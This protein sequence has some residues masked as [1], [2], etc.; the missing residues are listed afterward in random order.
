MHS[1]NDDTNGIPPGN[2]GHYLLQAGGLPH[3]AGGMNQAFGLRARL[4]A[5]FGL[6]TQPCGG[7]LHLL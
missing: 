7:L 2:W 3:Q 4:L 1:A 5:S 6:Q